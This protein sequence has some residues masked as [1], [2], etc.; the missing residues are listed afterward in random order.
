MQDEDLSPSPISELLMECFAG[1][2]GGAVGVPAAAAPLLVM[3]R[4]DGSCMAYKVR[5][6]C[7]RCATKQVA[8]LGGSWQSLFATRQWTI[9]AS[10][11]W[12]KSWPN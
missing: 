10:C 11:S 8:L 12:D 3:L 4:D 9:T 7:L 2:S 6:C 5:C 1:S